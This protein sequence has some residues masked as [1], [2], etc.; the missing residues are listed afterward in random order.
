[1]PA[2]LGV[3]SVAELFNTNTLKQKP[4]VKGRKKVVTPAYAKILKAREQQESGPA[5]GVAGQNKKRKSRSLTR[6][7]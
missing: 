4:K 1:M 2:K 7:E 6:A 3:E 5:K